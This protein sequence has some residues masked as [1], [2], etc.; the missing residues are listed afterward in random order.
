MNSVEM[1]SDNPSLVDFAA[2]E[3][4]DTQDNELGPGPVRQCGRVQ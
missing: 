2:F 3:M 1:I 4:T